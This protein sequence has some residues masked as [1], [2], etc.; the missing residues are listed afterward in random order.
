[1]HDAGPLHA[2]DAGQ[3]LAAMGDQRI[4]QRAGFVAGG[5]VNHQTARLLDDDDVVVLMDDIERDV[6]RFRLG[7]NGRRHANSDRIAGSDMISGVE[8]RGVPQRDLAR[9]DQ[10]FQP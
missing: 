7:G 8:D 3:A 5:G 6:L 2:A 10:R 9:E 4:D 1:M